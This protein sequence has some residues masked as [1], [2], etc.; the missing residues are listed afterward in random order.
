MMPS[1]EA[2]FK[3]P[4]IMG[5]ARSAG[6]AII[7]VAALTLSACRAPITPE[8]VLDDG[9]DV[10]R[11][12][13]S[14]GYASR[15]GA[16]DGGP[17]L[18]IR[19]VA[20][21][22]TSIPPELIFDALLPVLAQWN[23]HSDI[24]LV[25]MPS[26]GS[27]VDEPILALDLSAG[28]IERA[29]PRV[30]ERVPVAMIAVDPETAFPWPSFGVPPTPVDDESPSLMR[31]PGANAY[32]IGF[33]SSISG[34]SAQGYARARMHEGMA[35]ALA[36]EVIAEIVEDAQEHGARPPKDVLPEQDGPLIV[37][38]RDLRL[39]CGGAELSF[40]LHR[41]HDWYRRYVLPYDGG[42]GCELEVS[43]LYDRSDA[44]EI[45]SI[46][47]D[48]EPWQ[49]GEDLW[50]WQ[51]SRCRMAGG[52]GDWSP[53]RSLR[54]EPGDRLELRSS[55]RFQ[56]C[57]RRLQS[58][59]V[60]G[61]PSPSLRLDLKEDVPGQAG[62][63]TLFTV[64]RPE[65]LDEMAC[66]ERLPRADSRQRVVDWLFENGLAT[67]SANEASRPS[68][69]TLRTVGWSSVGR[70][71]GDWETH[72]ERREPHRELGRLLAAFELETDTQLCL[73]V[74]GYDRY[75][76]GAGSHADPPAPWSFDMKGEERLRSV[77]ASCAEIADSEEEGAF[78]F[79]TEVN[80][81]L[82]RLV[83]VA[84]FYDPRIEF[85]TLRGDARQQLEDW[86][87][88]PGRSFAVRLPPRNVAGVERSEEG[89]ALR[90]P[91]D[92]LAGSRHRHAVLQR[93][94]VPVAD[95]HVFDGIDE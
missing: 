64:L 20:I 86:S 41:Q 5:P 76:D 9:S 61:G 79:V 32:F 54:L 69:E 66:S 21:D 92:A 28:Q 36:D 70:E 29:H 1:D 37:L 16:P 94:D 52:D 75:D 24:E 14:S 30:H 34:S 12:G 3:G 33:T 74:L 93:Y 80:S 57:E 56:N 82:P 63:I 68:G 51:E 13:G 39:L 2:R 31:T 85:V 18:S 78:A 42:E 90:W 22:S 91:V 10:F 48:R 73:S 53:C 19:H 27:M 55:L 50:A 6:L 45:D 17:F 81:G 71:S 7:A 8:P 26:P 65:P 87:E 88:L 49:E 46:E 44:I 47:V 84:R 40:H 4:V 43:L 25:D 67:E 11:M 83:V 59:G 77:A 38:P 35:R 72:G 62:R 15:A 95:F 89:L 58:H 60:V 23:G